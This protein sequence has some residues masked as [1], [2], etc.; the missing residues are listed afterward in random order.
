[1]SEPASPYERQPP[2]AKKL[3][4]SVITAI[5]G[6]ALLLVLFVLPAEY[7]IDPTGV[8]KALGLTQLQSGTRTIQIVDVIGDNANIREVEIPDAGEPVPLPNP[9]IVQDEAAAPQTRS[10]QITLAAGE[11]TE[12]KAVLDESKVIVFSWVVEGGPIYVDFHGH[13]PEFGDDFWVRYKEQADATGSHGSLV[14]PFSGEHGWF[15][16]NHGNDP[17]TIQLTVTGYFV[18]VVD[19]GLF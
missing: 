14:A 10:L 7:G 12:V 6:A 3:L 17:V 4:T 9:A 1:M 8:G 5:V 16:Q 2:T 13:N 15:W 19:Y 11:R 18:D